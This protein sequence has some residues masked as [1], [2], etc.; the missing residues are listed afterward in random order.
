ME[1]KLF[2]SHREEVLAR[3]T[4]IKGVVVRDAMTTAHW[5]G[6]GGEERVK[7]R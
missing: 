1:A 7:V 4:K 2:A 3:K 6:A 5:Q